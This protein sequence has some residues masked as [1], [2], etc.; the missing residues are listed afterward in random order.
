[1]KKKSFAKL[2]LA[3]AIVGLIGFTGCMLG[4]G[5]DGQLLLVPALPAVI[6][7]EPSHNDYYQNGYYYTYENNIW[8]YSSSR[9]GPRKHLPR[10]HY[11]REIRYRHD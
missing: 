2:C 1:M 11:P 10:K 3:A 9:V 4:V 5:R 8:Y 7:F 6:E